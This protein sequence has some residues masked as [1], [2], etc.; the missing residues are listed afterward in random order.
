MTPARTVKLHTTMAA[1]WAVLA[2]ST[3]AWGLYDP[4]NRYLLA[5]LIFMSGYANMVGHL[6]GRAGAAPSAK[7]EP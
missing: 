3:T 1:I 2:L 7:E 6:A 5:W 4:E